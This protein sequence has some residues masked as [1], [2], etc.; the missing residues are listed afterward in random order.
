M[1]VMIAPMLSLSEIRSR[2]TAFAQRWEDDTS[3]DAEAKIFWHEFFQVF[4]VDR[5]RVAVFEKQVYRP[6]IFWRD[7]LRGLGEFRCC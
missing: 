1:M 2:A 5:K 3:E 6:P 4:G 7:F